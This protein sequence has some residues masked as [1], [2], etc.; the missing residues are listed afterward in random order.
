MRVN[1]TSDASMA[2][3][4]RRTST[5]PFTNASSPDSAY[6]PMSYSSD[7]KQSII[8]ETSDE[9]RTTLPS[10]K[11]NSH[12]W[13]RWHFFVLPFPSHTSLTETVCLLTRASYTSTG[14]I[15]DAGDEVSWDAL[16]SDKPSEDDL[17]SCKGSL[18][19]WEQGRNDLRRT[20]SDLMGISH[21]LLETVEKHYRETV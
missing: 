2:S 19:A 18:R 14:N 10:S 12:I 3:N 5:S 1:I 8:L 16:C 17:G 9:Q 21:A 20:A 11:T 13:N 6:A 4:K 7:S 15:F